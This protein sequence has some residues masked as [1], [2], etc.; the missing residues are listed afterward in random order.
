MTT[1]DRKLV[2]VVDADPGFVDAA[3]G[4]VRA[5]RSLA[6]ADLSEAHE[7]VLGGRVDLVVLGPAFAS[8]HSITQA[9]LLSQAD[10]TAGI[11]L[12]ADI[13]TNRLLKAAL[14]AGFSDVVDA[15]LTADALAGVL[16]VDEMP[17]ATEVDLVL[18]VADDAALAPPE[19]TIPPA[20]HPSQYEPEETIGSGN[21]WAMHD[22]TEIAAVPDPD[23]RPAIEDEP[24]AVPPPVAETAAPAVLV[25][26]E[27]EAPRVVPDA[28]PILPPEPEPW[29]DTA[30]AATAPTDGPVWPDEPSMIPP[31]EQPDAAPTAPRDPVPEPA[32]T[33]PLAP[34]P[35]P[36]QA[37]P[38]AAPPPPIPAPQ[39]GPPDVPPPVAPMPIPPS[40]GEPALPPVHLSPVGPSG[41]ARTGRVIAVMAG[42]G[43]S[44]KS[45]VATNLAVAIGLRND[46]ERVVIV[47]ADLQ[48]GDVALMLQVDPNRTLADVVG[49]LDSLT[50]ARL[51]AALLR[52][53]SG[54]RVLAAPLTPV[55]DDAIPAKSIVAVVDRLRSLYDTVVIDTGAIFGDGLITI[56]E[57]ADEVVAV[58]DMD[59]PSVKNAKVALDTLRGT[60]FPMD[61]ITL[62]VNRVNSKARLDLVE[63]ERSLGLRVGGS[64]PSDRLVPQ[65]VNEGIPLLA[66]SPRSKV[67]RS[68]M[69]LAERLDPTADRQRPRTGGR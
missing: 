56:L 4:L 68:F 64:V 52:H 49:Q 54:L 48:F 37:P 12:V 33:V 25:A 42:K 19:A 20:L 2:L 69:A 24:A 62:V 44:G 16:P 26:P 60:G 65:S 57:H 46:P 7:I 36:V 31:A 22:A 10:P 41:S 23:P 39:V 27:V 1:D 21:G 17:N 43:G 29:I 59:L 51:D 30:P 32:P 18:E 3:R 50:D 63:L 13:V 15:P 58:V 55:Q 34:E 35:V 28:P 67:A 47:D 9:A 5:H 45:V 11:V 53:E 6:A 14:R 61:R 38:P 40:P 66:L 8:E